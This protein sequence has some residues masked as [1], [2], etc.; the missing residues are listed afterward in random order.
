[1]RLTLKGVAVALKLRPELL[2]DFPADDILDKSK[3]SPLAKA[4]VCGQALWFCLQ[5]LG[6]L[7][8]STPLSLL[9]VSNFHLCLPLW[10]LNCLAEHFRPL[11]IRPNYLHS[12]VEQASRHRHANHP[13]RRQRP[14][15]A[16]LDVYANANG[17]N[18]SQQ[19]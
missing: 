15:N 14:R 13:S 12:M 5:C 3:A 8:S 9:E 17:R 18:G 2:Q 16:R 11:H 4:I 6:R 19:R 7:V 1:M 10:T